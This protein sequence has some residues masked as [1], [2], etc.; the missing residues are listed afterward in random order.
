MPLSLHEN[1]ASQQRSIWRLLWLCSGVFL[2]AA[3]AQP[4]P[5]RYY[6]LSALAT[7]SPAVSGHAPPTAWALE[8][9]ILPSGLDRNSLVRHLS[10]EGEV[11]VET[12]HLWHEPLA[13]GIRRIT[14]LNLARLLGETVSVHQDSRLAP[15]DALW[16]VWL[17]VQSLEL[18]GWDHVS[19]EVVWTVY[20]PNGTHQTGRFREQA[21]TQNA[22]AAESVQALNRLLLML[23]KRLAAAYPNLDGHSE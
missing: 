1:R 3:C 17:D 13:E 9:L 15:R 2:L 20:A 19:L 23:A 22:H 4:L 11:R 6:A 18:I 7:P 21:T 16:R 8:R 10:E 5:P 14:A 12:M